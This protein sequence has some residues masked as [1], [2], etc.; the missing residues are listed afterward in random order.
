MILAET[1][2]DHNDRHNVPMFNGKHWQAVSTVMKET[3]EEECDAKFN[4][5]NVNMYN[6]IQSPVTINAPRRIA[7]VPNER[8][9]SL[10]ILAET[11]KGFKGLT[12]QSTINNTA[13]YHSDKND[14]ESDPK[15]YQVVATHTSDRNKIKFTDTDT[16]NENFPEK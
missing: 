11:I 6:F 9:I 4:A 16:T 15:I 8:Q 13:Y 10:D 14:A 1:L 3:E 2:I 12:L 7:N 5:N